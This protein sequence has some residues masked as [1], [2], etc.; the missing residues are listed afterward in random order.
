MKPTCTVATLLERYF[1]ERLMRQRNVSPN[2]IA[3]ARPTIRLLFTLAQAR[4]PQSPSAL[5]TGQ[6]AASFLG[7]FLI[8][9]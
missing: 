7:Q 3:S 4:P 6:L 2:T 8:P 5:A 9:P 1:T